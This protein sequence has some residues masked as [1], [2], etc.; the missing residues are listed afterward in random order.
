MPNVFRIFTTSDGG[1]SIVREPLAMQP[2]TDAE[3]SHGLA[4]PMLS[5]AGIVFRQNPPGYALDWHCAPRRQYIIALGGVT[6]I[7][8]SDG[9]VVRMEPGDVALAEDLTGKGHTTRAIG[10]QA[11]FYA[12]VPIADTRQPTSPQP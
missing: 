9:T 10:P 12:V 4:T 8:A 7:E 5:A 6:Q 2:F 1:S 11:R 3:G